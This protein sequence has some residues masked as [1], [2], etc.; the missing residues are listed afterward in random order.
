MKNSETSKIILDK[1]TTFYHNKNDLAKL[2][3]SQLKKVFTMENV[4]LNGNDLN[5]A[6]VYRIIY[7]NYPVSVDET[8]IEKVRL[9][10]EKIMSQT[11]T[12]KMI[13]GFNMGFGQNQDVHVSHERL[14]QLQINLIR[15]HAISFGEPSPKEVVK[16]AMVLRANALLKGCS[17][18][19]PEVVYKL[20]EFINNPNL[21]PFVPKIGSLGASGD[22]SPLSHIALNLIGEGFCFYKTNDEDY[23]L[24]ET[25]LA[26][27]KEGIEPLQLEAKEGLALNNGMQFTTAYLAIL[28]L[29]MEKM[30]TSSLALAACFSEIMLATDLPFMDEIQKV[31]PYPGQIKSA[32]IL[33]NLL[34]GSGIILAH[35]DQKFD[36]NTQ[37]PYSS[38]CLP[39]IFGPVFDSI[40][41]TKKMLQIEMNSATDNPLV[42]DEAVVSGGN[43]HGMPIALSAANLFNAFCAQLKVKEALV[44]RIID[45]DKNRLGVSCLL[46]P[47]C[48][49]QT[50]SGMMILEYSYHAISNLI[51]SCNSPAFLFS[52]SSASCQEDHVSHAPTV[53]LNL[54]RALALFS[55]S[56][57][58]EVTMICQGYSVLKKKAP[59]MEKD[60]RI[61]PESNLQPGKI[62]SFLLKNTEGIFSPI[63][64]DTFLQ[65]TVERIRMELIETEKIYDFVTE[66]DC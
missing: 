51:M 23:E 55:N 50:S 1:K 54:E 29:K 21:Y 33:R 4:V 6:D 36:K 12:G 24:I 22:L 60:Q 42:F 10:R 57:A 27:R 43:F 39:Q 58:L 20:V 13:Y 41:A 35:R 48:D 2:A 53:I 26:L 66:I 8:A 46:D 59:E 38:R 47:T 28:I 44:R 19:R 56:L 5:L 61:S 14:A 15:S 34:E 63:S 25:S 30:V 31:R 64:V 11:T 16:L 49:H 7:G 17:G 65:P 9:S 52:A 37:D 40:E 32:K 18:V 62:G 3:L 45:K